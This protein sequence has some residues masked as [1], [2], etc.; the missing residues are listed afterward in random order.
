MKKKVT[1]KRN[2]QDS[3]TRNVKA[4]NKRLDKHATQIRDLEVSLDLLQVRVEM[5][6][7]R[8]FDRG[9]RQLTEKKPN[10]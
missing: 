6:I 3:T 10:D 1:K 9:A 2:P 7:G 4:A 8:I 5:L